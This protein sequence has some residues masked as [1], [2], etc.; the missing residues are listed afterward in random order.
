MLLLWAFFFQFE[1]HPE[2]IQPS[3]KLI[4]PSPEHEKYTSSGLDQNRSYRSHD[5]STVPMVTQDDVI[6]ARRKIHSTLDARVCPT[7]LCLF[8]SNCTFAAFILS[9]REL[10]LC[11]TCQSYS[12]VES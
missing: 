6:I 5:R 1:K 3:Y 10:F 8:S 11:F 7:M 2:P 9:L 4:E 12:V